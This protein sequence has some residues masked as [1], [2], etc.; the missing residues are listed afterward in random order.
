[1]IKR[2]IGILAWLGVLALVVFTV[3]G[4]GSYTSMLP[5]IKGAV[6]EDA[7]S[8]QSANVATDSAEAE[9]IDAADSEA[10]E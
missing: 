4:V 3:I 9:A 8:T 1:M 2:I 10:T 6:V 5:D 7:T